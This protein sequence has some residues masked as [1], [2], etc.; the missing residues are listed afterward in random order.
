MQIPLWLVLVTDLLLVAAAFYYGA[1]N[2]NSLDKW[3][4]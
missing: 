2:P 1:K 3:L 4:K